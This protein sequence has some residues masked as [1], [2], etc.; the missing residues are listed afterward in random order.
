MRVY[1]V[2]TTFFNTFYLHFGNC[3]QVYD[4]TA[5]M[6]DHPGGDEVLLAAT[7]NRS[8]PIHIFF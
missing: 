2:E 1:C 6:D 3:I 5:F 8:L 7:G 4:V